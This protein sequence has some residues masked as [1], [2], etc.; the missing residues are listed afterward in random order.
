M[1]TEDKG[2]IW[3]V[4]TKIQKDLDKIDEKWDTYILH[5]AK[6]S[7]DL[8]HMSEKVQELNKLLT[9]DNGKPSVITQIRDVSSTVTEVKSAIDT[10]RSDIEEV[11]VHVG[12][13]D[14]KEV[15]IERLK[16]VGKAIGL[17]SLT[18]PGIFSFVSGWLTP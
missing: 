15:R 14:P 3:F 2:T 6:L 9:Y 13:R 5:T 7:H 4:L 18:L 16:N 12:I 8:N 17:L 1:A 11:K 10:M